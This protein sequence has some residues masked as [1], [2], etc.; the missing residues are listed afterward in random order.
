MGNPIQRLDDSID[1]I[2]NLE[3]EYEKKSGEKASVDDIV[4]AAIKAADEDD[5]MEEV[6]RR[7][8]KKN[9]KKSRKKVSE[10]DQLFSL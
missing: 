5:L 9:K 7:K 8:K 1:D 3:K 10:F 2:W 6:R 4:S